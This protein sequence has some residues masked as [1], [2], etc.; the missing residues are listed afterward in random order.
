MLTLNTNSSVAAIYYALLQ[1]GYEYHLPERDAAHREAL[2]RF[3]GGDVPAF[4]RGVKQSTCEVYPYWP[5]AALLESALFYLTPDHT[6][7]ADLPAFRARV[8]NASNLTPEE[9]N[10]DLWEWIREFPSALQEVLA[11]PSFKE[12][13][14]WESNWLETQKALHS[15][16]LN[17]L[18]LT[19]AE[20]NS[21][22]GGRVKRVQL[23]LDPIKCVYSADYHIQGDTLYY[24]SGTLN[25]ESILHEFLHPILHPLMAEREDLPVDPTLDPS[26]TADPRYAAEETAVRRLTA[27]IL[28]GEFPQDLSSFLSSL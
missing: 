26:Y 20:C 28:K 19:L 5:R 14:A 12:Y 22:Y 4:F 7:W 9:R 24:C 16:V 8:M 23:W 27:A 18:E 13:L 6:A 11:S 10:D 15:D 3:R 17:A 2:E 1:W 25:P 21:L